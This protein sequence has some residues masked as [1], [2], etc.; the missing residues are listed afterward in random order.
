MR[1]QDIAMLPRMGLKA[2]T[3]GSTS[4]LSSCSVVLDCV[5]RLDSGTAS[6][7]DRENSSMPNC[8]KFENGACPDFGFCS[9]LCGASQLDSSAYVLEEAVGCDREIPRSLMTFSGG[10]PRLVISRHKFPIAL[11][12]SSGI[13]S[14]SYPAASERAPSQD[15]PRSWMEVIDPVA[16]WTGML[17]SCCGIPVSKLRRNRLTPLRRALA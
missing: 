16:S 15:D 7:S 10:T 3:G 14:R 5:S 1:L 8:P 17:H 2:E 13:V 6:G 9:R 4:G 12:F 11:Y